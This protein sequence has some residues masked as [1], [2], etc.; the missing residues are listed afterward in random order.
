[1][2]KKRILPILALVLFVLMVAVAA[3]AFAFQNTDIPK[4]YLDGDISKMESKSDERNITVRY[5]DG[6]SHFAGY[7]SLKVQGTSSLQ[8]DKKNYT[9]KFFSD[10]D[11]E[12]K[13]K[14]DLG[15]GEENKYCLKAN[16][17]DRTHARN[18]VSAKLVSQMQQQ[19]NLLTDAPCNGA[20]D[21]FPVEV[22]SNGDFLG[23]YTFNIPK[24]EWQF[25]MDGDDPNH[26]VIG[27]EMWEDANLFRA[28]PDFST[29]AVEVGPE[30]DETLEKMTALFR[31]IMDSTDE[32]FRANLED[33]VNLDAA[34][35]YYVFTDIAYLQDNL[36]KNILVATYDGQV[37]YP[38]LYDLDSS[39]GTNTRGNGLVEYEEKN[40]NIAK[41][42]LFERLETCFPQELAQRYQELRG[43]VL[44][45]EHIME[46]FNAFRDRIPTLTFMK[47]ALRWG[48]GLIRRTEDLPG[49][50]Y[51]QIQQFLDVT[52]PRLD[53]K[54]E[55]FA[56]Q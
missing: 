47:E 26:I 39:W 51:D 37:W 10:K 28:D 5:E 44:S 12:D 41:S 21:G 43:S 13:M 54:Y 45:T 31:F 40:L 34:L 42:L 14:V 27:G 36:G 25:G 6:T 29:W 38:S 18:V 16:W 30:T 8:Y 15:W 48:S 24:D 32:E 55:A 50:D 20:V 52:T 11:H 2:M 35:N 19:Y 9:I 23:L 22:Y 7:A 56:N 4:L 3:A 1:M 46:E 33:H 49:Y 53:A 17:I